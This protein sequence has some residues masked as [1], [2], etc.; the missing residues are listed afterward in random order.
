MNTRVGTLLPIL[1]IAL[2][3]SPMARGAAMPPALAGT[4]PVARDAVAAIDADPGVRRAQ[5]ERGAALARASG[6]RR[7]THEWVAGGQWLDRDAGTQGRFNEW[8]ASLQRELRLPGKAAVDR[9]IADAEESVGDDLLADARHTAAI[10]LLEA[11][12][13]WLAAEELRRVAARSVVDATADLDAIQAR[14][15]AGD[16]ALVEHDAALAAVAAA[17]REE[18]L[19][20]VRSQEARIT[21]Q[22]RYPG[23]PLPAE[24][25]PVAAPSMPEPGWTHWGERIVAVSHEVTLA[26]GRAELEARRAERARLDHR[27]NPTVGLRALSERGG[28]E[29]ALGVYFSVPLGTGARRS[30]AAEAAGQAMAAEANADAVRIE[31]DRHA[32]AL[33]ARAKTLVSA[34]T[35]A[36]E[37]L[38]A[39]RQETARLSEGRELGGVA[40][41]PVLAARRREREAAMAEVESRAAAYGATARLLLDAHAYWI[42]DDGHAG[43]THDAMANF[44]AP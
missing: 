44:V 33:A 3:G 30:I 38:D 28:D 25:A 40:L 41:A 14:L 20:D 19:T 29:T 27:A 4:L 32:R 17:R 7:G 13:E 5:G 42:N 22:A 11:W 6:R 23:L 36:K 34:W 10:N 24:P 37:G 26:Q 35:L 1:L 16:A 8:E 18:R 43:E 9:H 21:L 2:S 12:L 15:Q 39:Q 31:V